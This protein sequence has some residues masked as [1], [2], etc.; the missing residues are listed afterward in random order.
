[1]TTRWCCGALFKLLHLL[2]LSVL[3]IKVRVEVDH[4]SLVGLRSLDQ[5]CTLLTWVVRMWVTGR[6]KVP[7][8][9]N[10]YSPAAFFCN[11]K[12]V[13]ADLSPSQPVESSSFTYALTIS[14]GSVSEGKPQRVSTS[15]SCD[16]E[17]EEQAPQHQETLFNLQE[18]GFPR[19]PAE[20]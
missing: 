2:A 14:K 12:N 4:D 13:L 11:K 15:H 19:K 7:R 17:D 10:F 3:Q 6:C 8:V 9:F 18:H 5:P 20:I 16:A 1:M